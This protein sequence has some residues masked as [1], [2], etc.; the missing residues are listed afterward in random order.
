M[1]RLLKASSEA[2]INMDLNSQSTGNWMMGYG[3]TLNFGI[4][5]SKSKVAE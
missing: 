3:Y 2:G 5:F 1:Q 4:V